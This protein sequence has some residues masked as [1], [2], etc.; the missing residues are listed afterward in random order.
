MRIRSIKAVLCFRT[1]GWNGGRE[2]KGGREE[3]NREGGRGT[4]QDWAVS[5]G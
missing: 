1:E 4:I 3:E 2:K 5:E